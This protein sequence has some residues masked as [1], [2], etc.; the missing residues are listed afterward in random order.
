MNAKKIIFILL[1][2]NLLL[3]NCKKNNETKI[4]TEDN[5]SKNLDTN[6]SPLLKKVMEEHAIPGLSIGV[7]KDNQIVYAEG[8]GYKNTLTKTPVTNTTIFHMASI[9]KTFVATAIMQLVEQGKIDLDEKLITY[10]PYFKMADDSYKEITIRQ[11]LG[12][13]SGMPNSNDY[14]WTK[15]QYDEGAI[16]RFVRGLENEQ[17]ELTPGEKFRYSNVAFE[18]LGD[19]ISKVSGKSFSDYQKEYILNPSGMK[20]SSFLKSPGLPEN[21]ANPHAMNLEQQPL[22]MYPYNRRHAPSSTLHSNAIEMANYARM[23]LNDGLFENNQIISKK[24]YESLWNVNVKINEGDHEKYDIG[25]SWFIGNYKGYKT[26]SHGGGDDGFQTHLVLVPE[27]SIGVIVMVNTL[28]AP[29]EEI[30]NLV[31]DL[32]LN[33]TPTPIK[34]LASIPMWEILEEQDSNEAVLF[35]ENLK[36]NNTNEYNFELQQFFNLYFTVKYGKIEDA[37]K[38][39]LICK[40]VLKEE[41]VAYLKG[42]VQYAM[43]DNPNSEIGKSVLKI[44]EN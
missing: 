2:T 39:A 20:E 31:I 15:P 30:T 25:L 19:V 43:T 23:N 42:I 22:N 24:S 10:L 5:V 32:L 18:V 40:K 29:V 6:L 21:W 26:V 13:N 14:E 12:H 3:F 11:M 35:W 1:F 27:K 34:P 7:V 44:L 28:P 36:A 33:E 17:M 8:F 16:E 9:S 37:N 38:I 41:D 4:S